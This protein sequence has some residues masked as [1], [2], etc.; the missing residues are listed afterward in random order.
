MRALPIAVASIIA[1]GIAPSLRAAM[2]AGGHVRENWRGAALPF[3]FG[4]LVLAAAAVSLGPLVL[5][6]RLGTTSVFEGD[7]ASA[8]I[9]AGGVGALGMI[10]DTIGDGEAQPRG[11]RGH[12][13]A[14]LGGGSRPGR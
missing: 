14:V 11:W 8:L 13:G 10:D 6:A 7:V 1:L 9:Y 12:G 4:V 5:I 2:A 3:P